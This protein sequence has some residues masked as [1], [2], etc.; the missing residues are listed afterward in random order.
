M[1]LPSPPAVRSRPPALQA[2]STS[3]QTLATKFSSETTAKD[4]V[5]PAARLTSQHASRS[6]SLR[7]FGDI[8]A[9]DEA[10]SAGR[11]CL[12]DLMTTFRDSTTIPTWLRRTSNIEQAI[13]TFVAAEAFSHFLATGTLLSPSLV[14]HAK[15]QEY[16]SGSI[17]LAHE[18]SRYA[19]GRATL[20][21]ATSVAC[22]RAVVSSLL[23]EMLEFDL[24]N[25]SLRKH[26]DS[27]KYANKR[28]EELQYELSV[29]GTPL[30]DDTPEA[31]PSK[32]ARSD[33]ETLLDSAAFTRI[34]TAMD[35][36][37]E[38]REAVIKRTRDVQK[39]AKQS[40]FALHRGDFSKARSQIEEATKIAQEI[41]SQLISSEPSLRAGA[42][43]AA[44]EE[45]AEG[46][47]F[48][49]WLAGIN[50]ES[51][52]IAIPAFGDD[53][54]AGLLEAEEYLGGLVDLTGEIGRY[55]VECAT[56]RDTTS[57]DMCL[58]TSEA[59]REAIATMSGNVPLKVTKKAGAVGTNTSKIEKIRYEM[60]LQQATG[61]KIEVAD[62]HAAQTADGM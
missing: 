58:V 39:L 59:V 52:L 24:K 25:G 8:V 36:H 15:D 19:I 54:F 46:I 33:T 14:P 23:R 51:T 5:F 31:P 35:A 37:N 10:L 6:I 13:S 40:I 61:R 60:S 21:D 45:L 20:R 42:Y 1:P 34:R 17:S 47:L 50:R 27:L 49:Q 53:C 56:R 2:F 38:T 41:Q 30:P 62:M 28:L 4:S 22:C 32:K 44:M 48:E 29:T 18:L 43:A 9:A 7:Q 3:F 57:V 11:S 12:S 55:A 26:Y 16:L